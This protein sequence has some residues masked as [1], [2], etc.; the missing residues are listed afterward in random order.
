MK[1][2]LQIGHWCFMELQSLIKYSYAWNV[3]N[4]VDAKGVNIPSNF[5]VKTVNNTMQL[6]F[7]VIHYILFDEPKL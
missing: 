7:K 4:L 5:F 2:A 1:N 6:V 3:Y